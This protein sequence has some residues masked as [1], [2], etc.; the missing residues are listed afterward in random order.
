[1]SLVFV[2]Q[3]VLLTSPLVS[4]ALTSLTNSSNSAFLT[5]LFYTLSLSLLKST[6]V[7]SN[8]S[9]P[10]L[11]ILPF[12]LFK[13]ADPYSNLSISNSSTSYFKLAK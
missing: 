13:P 4:M 2:L 7:V 5:A 1:M 12:K 3:S 11:S 8:L 9:I 10:N 6:G